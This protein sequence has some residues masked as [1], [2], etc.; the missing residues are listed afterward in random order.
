MSYTA[1]NVRAS[2]LARLVKNDPSISNRGIIKALQ[3]S[4]NGR[5]SRIITERKKSLR[6]A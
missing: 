1:K 3:I 6:L 2:E 5:N 4:N